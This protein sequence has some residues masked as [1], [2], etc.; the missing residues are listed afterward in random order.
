[1]SDLVKAPSL[2]LI[3]IRDILAPVIYS[4]GNMACYSWFFIRLLYYPQ[5]Q[6]GTSL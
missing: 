4:S 3:N 5:N 2:H 6:E 1:M